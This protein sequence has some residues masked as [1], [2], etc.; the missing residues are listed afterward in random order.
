MNKNPINPKVKDIFDYD[1]ETG[2]ITWKVHKHP[3]RIGKPAGTI[4]PNGGVILQLKIDGKAYRYQAARVIWFLHSNED[5]G[6]MCIDHINRN[7]AD[8]RW[9]NLRL[10]TH[11]ENAWN[12][13]G[14]KGYSKNRNSWMVCIRDNTVTPVVI[15]F[16][17]CYRTEEE[18]A[19]AYKE[20]I[21]RLRQG[22]TPE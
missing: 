6:N 22:F 19:A 12:R 10:V 16:Q 13:S 1:P 14:V 8:N 5:P 15:L 7:R 3:K 17:K 11:R 9:E 21:E 18:A 2:E 4:A 20:Q